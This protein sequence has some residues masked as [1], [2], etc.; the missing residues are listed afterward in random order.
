[1][2][3]RHGAGISPADAKNTSIGDAQLAKPQTIEKSWDRCRSYG[4]D[5]TDKPDFGPLRSDFLSEE[6]EKNHNLVSHALP[7]LETLYQQ[8]AGTHSMVVLTD[9]QGLVLHSLGDTDFLERAQRVALQPGVTWSEDSRGTNAIGTALIERSPIC[10][11]GAEH[12]LK[13]NRFL[14]CSAVPISDPRGRMVGVLDVTGDHRGYNSHTIALVKMS[15]QMIEN[16]LFS[17]AFPEGIAIH[18]HG[19]PEF[20]GTLCE[21]IVCFSPDG[22]FISAN[23]SAC[24]M[25]GR[26]LADL[27]THTFSTLFGNRIQNVLDQ[28]MAQG[29]VPLRLSLA[30]GTPVLGRV[31][32]GSRARRPMRIFTFDRTG[33]PQGDAG[34]QRPIPGVGALDG[35]MTGDAQIEAVCNKVRRVLG[36]DITILIQ[37]E[38]GT[39]KE[40]IANAIHE[41]SPRAGSPFVAV[42]CASIPDTLIESELFGYEEGAFTGAKRKGN[43]GKILQAGGGTLFLDEIGDMPL[44]LQ[45]RL[46][47]VLQE[48]KV[49]PLGSIKSYPVDI[50]IVCATNRKLRDM[51]SRG[52]FREDLYYRLNGL[53]VNLP[54]LRTRSDIRTVVERILHKEAHAGSRPRVDDEVMRMFL[55]HPWPGNLRQLTCLLRTALVMADEDGEIRREH[56]PDD[57]LDELVEPPPRGEPRPQVAAATAVGDLRASF[58]DRLDDLELQAIREA[59]EKHRGNVSAAS[60]QLGISRNTIYRKMK[61]L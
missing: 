52:E 34:D 28:A 43:A 4:L 26:S 27:R 39:G 42:N 59:L 21:G 22:E 15:A 18:M 16:H 5:L 60:R 19:R 61:S 56:L 47:R 46:L 1:M 38:T 10:V 7:V 25:L 11:N 17:D 37:G 3:Q 29:D 35:L 51:V 53:T 40:L 8:L 41:D 12:F 48:R 30:S 20:L 49:T 45:A 32:I 50:A 31:R 33:R 24:S 44:N 23:R 9:E 36:R 2:A 58:S 6:L 57:F 55:R 13:A 54:P 14:T